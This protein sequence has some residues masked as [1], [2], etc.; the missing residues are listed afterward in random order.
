MENVDGYGR[1]TGTVLHGKS[2]HAVVPENLSIK[3]FRE[4]LLA[5][6]IV[7]RTGHKQM[8]FIFIFGFI[9]A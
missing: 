6:M 5:S 1:Y 7:P 8:H 3:T 2:M 9:V 4:V